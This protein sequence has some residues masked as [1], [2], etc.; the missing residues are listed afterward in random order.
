VTE[1][2]IN[3]QFRGPPNSGNGGYVCGIVGREIEGA[4]T[5]ALR[6]LIP[7]DTSLQLEG[8]EGVVLLTGQDGTLI[9]QGSPSATALPDPSSPSRFIRP[10]S[11]AAPSARRVTDFASCPARSKARLPVISPAYGRRIRPSRTPMG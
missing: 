3:H 6:A 10:V 5:V 1:I 11:R 9:A 8:G 4:A 7:L 2:V